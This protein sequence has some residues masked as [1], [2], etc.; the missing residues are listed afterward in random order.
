MAHG[1]YGMP[2]TMPPMKFKKIKGAGGEAGTLAKP[3][4]GKKAKTGS[5]RATGQK[6][7]RK[8]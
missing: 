2:T 4:M 3:A 6:G 1:D 5:R 7:R 8:G